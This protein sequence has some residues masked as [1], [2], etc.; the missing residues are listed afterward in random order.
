MPPTFGK[1][2]ADSPLRQLKHR[3][4]GFAKCISAECARSLLNARPA[5]L[6]TH[7]N[8]INRVFIP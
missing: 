4:F 1:H 5:S 3:R 6:E 2:R 7:H 8:A